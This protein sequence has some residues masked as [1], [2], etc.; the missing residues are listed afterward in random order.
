MKKIKEM[1]INL[2]ESDK[3]FIELVIVMIVTMLVF[4]PAMA[5]VTPTKPINIE[6][7]VQEKGADSTR[8][9]GTITVKK[10]TVDGKTEVNVYK[11]YRGS[12]GGYFYYTGK[13]NKQGKPEK[14]YL[15]KKQKEEKGLK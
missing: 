9:V 15:T 8:C 11:L 7:E 12:R 6:I 1:W 4:F 13:L 14:K 2:H 3:F 10:K 5:Q